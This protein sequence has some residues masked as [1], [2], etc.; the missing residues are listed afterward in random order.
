MAVSLR[1]L[2]KV[3]V[4]LVISQSCRV[5]GYQQLLQFT[6]RFAGKLD[7]ELDFHLAKQAQRH[8][9]ACQA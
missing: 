9:H 3:E 6:R 5:D 4:E 2:S 8:G 1:L 7:D